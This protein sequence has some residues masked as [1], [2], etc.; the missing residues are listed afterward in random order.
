MKLLQLE[1]WL[2]ACYYVVVV[3]GGGVVH[4]WAPV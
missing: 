4:R 2:L 3:G 1:Y